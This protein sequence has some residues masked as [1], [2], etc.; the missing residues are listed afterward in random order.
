MCSQ[1]RSTFFGVASTLFL[2]LC[3]LASP[4]NSKLLWLVPP[5]AQI[6]AGFEN[7]HSPGHHGQLLLTTRNNRLD[8]ADWQAIAGVDHNRAFEEVVEVAASSIGGQLSDHMLLVAGRFSA[9]AI[10]KSLELN[11][12]KKI[13]V[14]GQTVMLIEPYPREKG[15]LSGTRWLVILQDRLVMLGTPKMVQAGLLRYV[16]H[17]DIDMILRERLA[18]L[19]RE[20]SSWNVLS[21]MSSS[22]TQYRASLSSSPW[23]KFFEG[24]KVMIV[25]AHFGSKIHLHFSLHASEDRGADFFAQ[26]PRF[27]AEV[28]APE[29]TGSSRP[30][31]L[32]ELEIAPGSVQGSIELS[33]KQFD[34]WSDWTNNFGRAPAIPDRIASSGQ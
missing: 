4:T 32:Q 25:G 8:L 29:R 22:P 30:P 19:P 33:G 12:A 6:V 21:S 20:V 26:K 15:L 5:G 11:G 17:A 3:C 24:A 14:E 31:R 27:F 9:A 7:Y 13:E 34:A 1:V 23:E 16:N 28:F 10:F 18:Q 2:S